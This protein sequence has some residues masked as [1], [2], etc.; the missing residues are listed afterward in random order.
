M[1]TW[2]V[3]IIATSDMGDERR[4]HL[5]LQMDQLKTPLSFVSGPAISGTPQ[6]GQELSCVAAVEGAKSGD[7]SFQWLRDGRPIPGATAA[8]YRLGAA[9]DRTAVGCTIVA[10]GDGGASISAE[11]PAVAVTYAPP[12]ATGT[13]PDKSYTFATGDQTFGV[14][15]SFGGENLTYAVSGA[16]AQIDPA[17][18]TITIPTDALLDGALVTV[19][20]SNSGG[21]V[22][23]AFSVNVS[24]PTNKTIHIAN[25]GS[26]GGDGSLSAPVASLA[27]AMAL[28]SQGDTIA[29]A[30]GSV[31]R[32]TLKVSN[33]GIKITAY[34][35]GKL[36]VISGATT[37]SGLQGGAP[38]AAPD[39]KRIDHATGDLSQWNA[40]GGTGM[41]ASTAQKRS[42]TH[43][44][45]VPRATASA[46]AN[47]PALVSGDERYFFFALYMPAGS[48][49]V[50]EHNLARLVAGG[51]QLCTLQFRTTSD[52]SGRLNGVQLYRNLGGFAAWV[53]W[54]AVDMP[55]GRW[56]TVEVRVKVGS[57][58]G[59]AQIF[60]NGASVA[61]VKNLNTSALV[62]ANNIRIYGVTNIAAG[63]VWYADDVGIATFRI[64]R[65]G[66]ADLWTAS[67]ATNPAQVFIAGERGQRVAS[68][69]A[70]NSLRKWHWA[71]G[72]LTLCGAADGSEPAV[73]ASV[74]ETCLD[75]QDRSGIFVEKIR[76]E[77]A[78]RQCILARTLDKSTIRDCEVVGGYVDGIQLGG[79]ALR[80]DMLIK[81][82]Y[83]ADCGG[84]GIGFGGR[85]SNWIIEDNEVVACGTLTQAVVGIGDNREAAF[86][87]TSGI[88]N[89]GW[90]GPGWQGYVAI[91]RNTVRD[92]RPVAW[93]P[94][95]G[96]VHG[97]GIWLDEVLKPTARPEIHDNIVFNCHSRGIYLEKTDDHD[98][99]NNLVYDCASARYCAGIEVQTNPYGY[100][101]ALDQPDNNAPRQ[102]SG[103]RLWNNTAVGGWW[104]FSCS[105]SSPNCSISNTMVRDNIFCGRNGGSAELYI[106]GGG[107]NDGTHGS[108]NSY[109]NNCFGP[110][111]G[112]WVWGGT[113]YTTLAAF[114]GAS[115][116]AVTKSIAAN[117]LF[118]NPAA[119]DYRLNASSPCLDAA[120]DGRGEVGLMQS[121]TAGA[122]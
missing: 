113:A 25:G 34:G 111:G 55:E 74:R 80:T 71:G 18:G 114:A 64:G 20:A 78:G 117:P 36:P 95:P 57:T 43:S 97:H 84:A 26:D 118:R 76:L 48:T 16:G 82:N 23:R 87:W 96:E 116:G 38:E 2:G 3:E 107:A 120:S 62:G 109:V 70:V 53:G 6:V 42:G 44:L 104:S 63:T 17:T 89:W 22:T 81:G 52:S 115:R 121:G 98:V 106:V 1:G 99:F 56:H 108:G 27:K 24:R 47:F 92:C 7:I 69:A 110:E 90:G 4:F 60:I 11:A 51:T 61:N 101:V 79:Q 94:N 72:T 59:E 100:D 102:V 12:R 39:V 86:G 119:A 83:I 33:N 91:R 50:V 105:A 65:A 31:W 54:T 40:V 19:T 9:D 14:A 29:L 85:L 68:A 5:S 46:R 77:R 41:V 88:K 10:L 21:S 66:S 112:G 93:A 28:A 49:T 15:T 30:R 58:A 35:S 13:L 8:T 45:V 37:V 122:A 32:D 67:L 103:N 73:E 75:L